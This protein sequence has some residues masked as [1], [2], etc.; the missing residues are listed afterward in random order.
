MLRI[1]NCRNAV[2]AIFLICP[3]LAAD[4]TPDTKGDVREYR[5][6]ENAVAA[7]IAPAGAAGQTGYLGAAVQRDSQGR[8]VVEAVQPNS[9]AAKAG[10]KPGDAVARIG[11]QIVKTPE[12]FREWLQARGPGES[13][14]LSLIRG[15]EPVEVT[16]T[17]VA[18][19][20]P[21][22]VG[23]VRVFFGAETA[24]P[25]EDEG[26][27]VERVA[28]ESPAATAGVKVGD[29]LIRA[30]SSDLTRGG[31]L[32]DILAEKR[33]G[34]AL[35]FA[36]RRDGKEVTLTA[37]LIADRG[38]GG[39]GGGRAQGSGGRGPGGDG[40]PGALWKKNAIRLALIGIEF[41]DIKHNDKVP[42]TEWEQAFFSSGA[43]QGKTNATGQDIHGSLNDYYRE[44]S[45]GAL[46][47]EGK[48]LPW[49]E[50]GKKRGEYIQGSGTS[51]K[52]AVLVEALDKVAK[53]DG[54]EALKDFDAFLFIYAGER[55]NTNRGAVYYP[56]A[57]T[58]NFQNKRTP[59][60]LGV[61]GGSKM[62]PIGGFAKELGRVIGLPDLA[63]R[64]EN[65]GSEGLGPWCA[66]SNPFST[67]RPQHFSA[68]AK[69]KIGWITPTVIDPTVKQKLILEPIAQDQERRHVA[70]RLLDGIAQRLTVATWGTG[71]PPAR[72]GLQE[73]VEQ[74]VHD[75]RKLS[76]LLHPPMLEE[77]GLETALRARLDQY[78][79]STGLTASLAASELG[80]LPAELELTIFRVVEEALANVQPHSGIATSR[81]TIE[82]GPQSTSDGVVLIVETGVRG[83]PSMASFGALIKRMT[84]TTTGWGLGLARMRERV[85]RIGGSLE[86]SSTSNR[87]TVRATFPV[88]LA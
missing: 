30:E 25:K 27:K 24:A 72:V 46:S 29:F 40:P 65:Q 44:Q 81:I 19:S 18:T 10:V 39:G 13:V 80:R 36:V 83:M 34:D 78:T 26:A 3:V 35:A 63:A 69:E 71:E 85:Q 22:K 41:P 58:V 88:T 7:K 12:A 28:P 57:G 31:R 87:T 15:Q 49:I 32:T 42:V 9:P 33:P 73:T 8:L 54:A 45:G 2:G 5:T 61:E 11:E 20:R 50:V 56:H 16:A 82:H 86:I 84:A 75:L 64:P 52:T 1:L 21:M 62:T 79:R 60:L 43:Y 59:Y 37:T 68:W 55:V 47:I 76:Y 53:R 48:A 17:L 14:K 77:A 23:G 70:T 6:V 67:S 74:S 38:G 66:L 51:N 4:T